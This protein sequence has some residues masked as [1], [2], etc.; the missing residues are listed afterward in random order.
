MEADYVVAL[1]S[2]DPALELP[3]SAFSNAASAEG[4]HT[5]AAPAANAPAA[6]KYFDLKRSPE[7]LSLVPEAQRHP[8]LSEFLARINTFAFPMET[9]KCDVW[10]AHE[11]SPEEQIFAAVQKLVSYV[12]LV[13]SAAEGRLS[14][15]RH[16]ELAQTLC[17]LLRAAPEMAAAIEFVVR[18]CYYHE[19]AE[20]DSSVTGFCITAYVTGYGGNDEEAHQRWAIALK[21]LQNAL[22]QT[23]R[24]RG[25][26][27]LNSGE[28]C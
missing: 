28:R 18:R 24:F 3:W 9:A 5:I 11:L 4:A 27:S 13:F 22:V 12:D 1:G 21:L 15:S 10:M 19:G 8:E 7:L 16:E 23:V 26:S 25:Y 14:F 2:D 20:A 17:R 6:A